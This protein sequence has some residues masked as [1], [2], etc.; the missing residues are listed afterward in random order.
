MINIKI[1]YTSGLQPKGLLSNHPKLQRLGV[2][3]YDQMPGVHQNADILLFPTIREW[4]G[5]AAAEA[6]SCRLLVVATDCSSL[7][8]LIDRGKGEFLRPMGDVNT[9]TNRIRRLA[10][11][12]QL[13]E[14][15]YE[16]IK[17]FFWGKCADDTLGVYEN[18]LE[19]NR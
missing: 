7:P 3:P 8:E 9:F 2:V 10:K 16:R 6:M 14:K 5:L 17:M 11:N 18:I 4:F 19:M 1:I 12:A 15:G 13:I